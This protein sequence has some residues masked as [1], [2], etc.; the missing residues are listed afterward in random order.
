MNDPFLFQVLSTTRDVR[1]DIRL[2]HR[3][4]DR[5]WLVSAV[6]SGAA[7]TGAKDSEMMSS[8]VKKEKRM[9]IKKNK[10]AEVA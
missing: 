10:E 3:L 1:L 6:N 9:R 5:S 4:K 2:M 8:V 7:G